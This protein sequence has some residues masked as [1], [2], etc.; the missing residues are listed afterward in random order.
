MDANPF[1]LNDTAAYRSWRAAKLAGYPVALEDLRVR[2]ARLGQPSPEERAAIGARVARYNLAL[3]QTDAEQIEPTTLLAFGQALGL[4]R[5]DAN[6]FADAQAVSAITP[7]ANPAEGTGSADRRADYIPYTTKGLSW[8]T[9]GYYNPPEA[10]VRAW[11]LFCARPAASGG[12]NG[13]LDHEMVYLL[14]RDRDPTLIEALAHPHALTIP[15]NEQDGRVLRPASVGPVFSVANGRLHMRYSARGR[16]VRWRDDAPTRAARAALDELFSRPPDCTF[17]YRLAA[18]EG[19]ISRNVLH[20]RTAFSDGTQP[21]AAR[22]LLYR[23]RYLDDLNDP[24]ER[25]SSGAA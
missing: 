15:A 5:T 12:E 10:Q 16:N 24:D 7:A 17:H 23:V 11:T 25:G 6:P 22:R 20:H 9:D 1:D 8:H 2:V 14:L 19:V 3:I 21:A 18:G 13:L 4:S